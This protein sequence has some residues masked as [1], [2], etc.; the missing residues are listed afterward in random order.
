VFTGPGPRRH[1][2]TAATVVAAMAISSACS[3]ATIIIPRDDRVFVAAL[4]RMDRTQKTIA[5]SAPTP[6]E[7]VL[8]MM[9]EGLSRYRLEFP[10]RSLG[11]YLAQA[12]AVAIELPALQSIAGSMD[13]FQLRLKT[14]DGAVQLWETLLAWY[15]QS[16]LRPLTLYRLGWAYRNTAAGGL[17]RESGDQAFDELLRD[18]PR[19]T[20][21]ALALDA[22]NAPWKSTEA[23]T[24]WSIIPG[25]GQM[26]VGE[27][28]NGAVRLGV[29]VVAGAMVLVPGIIGYGRRDELSWGHDWPLLASAVAGLILLSVNYSL[30]YEDAIRG[31]VECNERAQERFEAQHPE[32]P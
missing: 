16:V 27:T 22:K 13:L 12:T 28:G 9:A 11:V 6:A 26:Y 7:S 17:P 31:V 24:A 1:A 19:S 14:S 29:G 18:Y 2:G 8:F 3:H 20:L 25:A 10:K 32:A 4:A 5:V 15:P 23:A 30:A 21:S